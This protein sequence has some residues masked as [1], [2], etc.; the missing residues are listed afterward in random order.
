M[1]GDIHHVTRQQSIGRGKYLPSFD[2]CLF[3]TLKINSCPHTWMGCFHG[4]SMNLDTPDLGWNFGGINH[5][6][7]PNL[8]LPGYE[9]TGDNR[10]ESFHTKD[11]VHRQTKQ[12]G[13]GTLGY[14]DSY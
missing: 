6:I 5:D 1:Q 4:F 7:I 8:D 9:R 12:I 14:A 3:K 13:G 11:P 10:A 2:G